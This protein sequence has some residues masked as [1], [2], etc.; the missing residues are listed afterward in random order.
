MPWASRNGV[1]AVSQN[2]E[3][4]V[5]I[6]LATGQEREAIIAHVSNQLQEIAQVLSHIVFKQQ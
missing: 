2:D 1:L 4:A 6:L 5:G 3:F